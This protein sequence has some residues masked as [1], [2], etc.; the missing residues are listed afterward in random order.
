MLLG[1]LLLC[2]TAHA[3]LEGEYELISGRKAGCPDGSLHTFVTDDKLNRILIFGSRDNWTL[4]LTKDEFES[5]DVDEKGCTE[6]QRYKKSENSFT[7]RSVYSGCTPKSENG[8]KT[9]RMTLQGDRL[10][11]EGQRPNKFSFKCLYKRTGDL[12]P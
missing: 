8:V 12:K 2:G 10:T 6:I 3:G 1:A 9:Q 4:H 11:Y 5:K 7:V